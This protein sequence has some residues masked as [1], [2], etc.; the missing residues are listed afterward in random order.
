M[1]Y[2]EH[3]PVDPKLD[4]GVKRPFL[5]TPAG[6]ALCVFFAIAGV[7]LLIEHRAH[8]LGTLPLLLPLLI[9]IGMHFFMHRGRGGHGNHGGQSGDHDE[10]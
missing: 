4:E 10:R 2:H 3:D 6:I 7:F 5:S 8:V 9:C 1:T